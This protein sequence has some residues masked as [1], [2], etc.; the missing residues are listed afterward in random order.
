MKKIK[1]SV[2]LLILA[3]PVLTLS[4]R[5]E[6]LVAPVSPVS[7]VTELAEVSVTEAG[8][9]GGWFK[10]REEVAVPARPIE[11]TREDVDR[12]R[13]VPKRL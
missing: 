10:K 8:V 2:I 4:V 1:Y 11:T 5:G 3:L 7:P 6:V 9:F 12:I 13:I